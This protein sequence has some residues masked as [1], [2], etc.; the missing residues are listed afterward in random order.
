MKKI[1]LNIVGIGLTAVG[2][3]VTVVQAVV[4]EKQQKATIQE[5]VQKA[6]KNLQ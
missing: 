1:P 4:G 5:E 6:I 3:I 2:A